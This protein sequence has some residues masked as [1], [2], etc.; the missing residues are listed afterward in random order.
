MCTSAYTPEYLCLYACL[1]LCATV[2]VLHAYDKFMRTTA[3]R[4]IDADGGAQVFRLQ[5]CKSH[6]NPMTF[7]T[8]SVM[9]SP[10][11]FKNYDCSDFF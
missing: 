11:P 5:N 9:K 4:P 2:C 7:Q 10:K 6:S 3:V 1:C 8:F